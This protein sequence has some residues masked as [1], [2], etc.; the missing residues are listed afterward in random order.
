MR[1]IIYLLFALFLVLFVCSCTSD[2]QDAPQYSNEYE[3]GYADAASQ[4]E[5]LCEDAIQNYVDEIKHTDT[6]GDV[7]LMLEEDAIEYVREGCDWH[8]EEALHIIQAYERGETYYGSYRIT[9]TDYKEAVRSLCRFYSF[10][11]EREYQ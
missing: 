3:Q 2:H 7:A 8:P 10:F 5:E 1:K 4:Y 9:D 6:Y 11:Y